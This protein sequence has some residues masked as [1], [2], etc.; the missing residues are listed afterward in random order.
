MTM[1][2]KKTKKNEELPV[3]KIPCSFNYDLYILKEGKGKPKQY[4][5]IYII[6]YQIKSYRS[7]SPKE[8]KR[9]TKTYTIYILNS[10]PSKYPFMHAN[11]NIDV[12]CLN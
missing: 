6:S 4:I 8:G 2:V 5:Y 11:I 3:L 7:F 10:L 12:L 9:Q 1:A